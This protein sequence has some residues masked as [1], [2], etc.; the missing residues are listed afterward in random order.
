MSIDMVWR[1]AVDTNAVE[2]ISGSITVLSETTYGDADCNG[3]TD[4]ADLVYL[5]D[6]MFRGGPLLPCPVN[7]EC[8][9][10]DEITV[11]ELVCLVQW[12]FPRH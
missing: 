6:Y 3:H 12:M 11:S 4:I 2:L 1:C 10:D 7:L 9:G 5:V 8:D